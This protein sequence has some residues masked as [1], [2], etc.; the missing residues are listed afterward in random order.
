MDLCKSDCLAILEFIQSC[1]GSENSRGDLDRIFRRLQHL[2]PF[3]SAIIGSGVVRG[4]Q[5]DS[6]LDLY[7]YGRNLWIEE[8]RRC[9]FER[10]DPIMLRALHDAKPF[11]WSEALASHPYRAK[12]YLDLKGGFDL[13]DGMAAACRAR[14]DQTRTTLISLAV[15]E[16][17]IPRRHLAIFEHV[18][19][20]IN[21][22]Y[23]RTPAGRAAPTAPGLTSR[24]LEIL[25]WVKEGKSSWDIGMLLSISERTVKFH[26][27][28][29]FAKLDVSNRA[30]AV[31]RAAR[32]GL[33][34][35]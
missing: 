30:Q 18:F 29:L 5:I 16:K 31:A 23:L 12:E 13:T 19:P 3:D 32:L 10:V 17:A 26:V 35:L 11:R 9:Q 8:Y 15:P 21:E 20:H 27:A 22:L 1:V 6:V 28:N 34:E 4:G 7:S 33:L 24:E 25:K 2:I 14:S